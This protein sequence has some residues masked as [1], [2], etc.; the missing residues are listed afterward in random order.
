[1]CISR[2][3][4]ICD[5]HEAML[6]MMQRRINE[7]TGVHDAFPSSI[8]RALRAQNRLMRTFLKNIFVLKIHYLGK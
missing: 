4:R 3:L 7:V 8:D 2:A 1:M 6:S 5:A